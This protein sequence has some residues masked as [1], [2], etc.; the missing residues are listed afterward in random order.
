MRVDCN[1]ANSHLCHLTS[2]CVLVYPNL[3]VLSQGILDQGRGVL[4]VFEE[5]ATDQTYTTALDTISQLGRVVD[6]LYS[7]YKVHKAKHLQ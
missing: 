3:S 1:W 5:S 4:I 7:T 6:A 2:L